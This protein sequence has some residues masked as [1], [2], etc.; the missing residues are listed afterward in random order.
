MDRPLDTTSGLDATLR[1]KA[2]SEIDQTVTW[3]PDWGRSRIR[4]M[5]EN[6]PDWCISRQRTWGVPIPV[7]PLRGV[8]RVGGEPGA[9]GAGG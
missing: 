2:L 7:A 5:V 3:V 1:S 8:R 4:G 9:H 6:R